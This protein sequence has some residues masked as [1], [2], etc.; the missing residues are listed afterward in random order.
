MIES[1]QDHTE[2]WADNVEYC[3]SMTRTK[4]AEEHLILTSCVCAIHIIQLFALCLGIYCCTY[5]AL[6]LFVY[7]NYA[8]RCGRKHGDDEGMH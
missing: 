8:F 1:M 3:E 4:G 5:S 2:R 6:I 7:Y